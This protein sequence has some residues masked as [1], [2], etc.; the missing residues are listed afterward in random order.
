MRTFAL[1]A[2]SEIE[3]TV[4]YLWTDKRITVTSGTRTAREQA[5]AMYDISPHLRGRAVDIRTRDMSGEE[6]RIFDVLAISLHFRPLSEQDHYHLQF[7]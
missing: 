1:A 4:Y 6:R 2:L 7:P 5:E 3:G